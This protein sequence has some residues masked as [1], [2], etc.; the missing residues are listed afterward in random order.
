[1]VWGLA[2]RCC[3]RRCVKKRSN[4]GA[5]LVSGVMADP[6]SGARAGASPRAATIVTDAV[7][8]GSKA[9]EASPTVPLSLIPWLL[10]SGAAAR[11][12]WLGLGVLHL[13]RLRVRSV[14]AALDSGV[15]A[16]KHALAPH[17]DL[18]WDELVDQP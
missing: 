5:K 7:D 9:T 14:P 2:W 13:G 16:L 8:R 11:G 6:P 12:A 17:A 3:I 1:M 15:E 18:R 10:L 4:S